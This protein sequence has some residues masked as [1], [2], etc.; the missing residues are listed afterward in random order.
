MTENITETFRDNASTPRLLVSVS[1]GS[2]AA[3][4]LAGGCRILDVKDPSRGPLGRADCSVIEDV[5]DIGVAA[6]IPVSAAMG[7][8]ADWDFDTTECLAEPRLSPALSKLSFLKIGLAGLGHDSHWPTRWQNAMSRLSE[9]L[10]QG[11]VER[12]RRWVAVIYADWQTADAPSPDKIVD[13]VLS[14]NSP[15]G[16]CI[17]G[18][19]VDTWSKRSGRLLDSLSIKQLQNLGERVQQ[20]SRFFAIA[21]RLQTQTLSTLVPIRPDVVAVRSAACR[22]EDRTAT[23]DAAAVRR[24]RLEIDQVFG[25]TSAELVLPVGAADDQC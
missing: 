13:C 10:P 18:V 20:S 15:A 19:L 14:G 25:S 11:A 21:G 9:S 6:D 12:D 17:A 3:D 1:S 5:L 23:V 24:L 16:T 2:E 4:A 8:V 7:E 22:G